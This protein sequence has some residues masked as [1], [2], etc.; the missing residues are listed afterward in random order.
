MNDGSWLNYKEKVYEILI[1]NDRNIFTGKEGLSIEEDTNAAVQL[2]V[3]I[4][5]DVEKEEE[6]KDDKQKEKDL[7]S[8]LLQALLLEL[9]PFL[10]QKSKKP[11]SSYGPE[12][13]AR[14]LPMENKFPQNSHSFDEFNQVMQSNNW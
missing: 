4:D 5:D 2:E 8:V 14:D 13:R 6:E 10:K 1:S 11:T 12:M 7:L 3:I 9:W